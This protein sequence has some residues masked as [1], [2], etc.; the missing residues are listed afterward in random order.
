MNEF[1]AAARRAPD[2]AETAYT[3]FPCE[4]TCST[5]G[6]EVTIG[7]E[8]VGVVEAIAFSHNHQ[9]HGK[10]YVDRF[11]YKDGG[12]LVPLRQLHQ[13]LKYPEVDLRS[14][15][16][17]IGPQIRRGRVFNR[18]RFQPAEVGADTRFSF[19]LREKAT[20][21]RVERDIPALGHAADVV[22][23]SDPPP[24]PDQ[25]QREFSIVK[26]TEIDRTETLEAMVPVV[27]VDE[28][29][30]PTCHRADRKK[31]RRVAHKGNQTPGG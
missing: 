5:A 27:A 19:K 3:F 31:P 12:L 30:S 25:L 11:L 7:R 6:R 17:E 14:Q 15:I 23:R 20:L 4:R 8:Q 10:H 22:P 9:V 2:E 29:R 1:T 16:G 26:S 13:V 28:E 21:V 18:S 24:R